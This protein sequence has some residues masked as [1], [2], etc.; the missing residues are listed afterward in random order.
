M[1]DFL[2]NYR[3]IANET[4]GLI[5]LAVLQMLL[6]AVVLKQSHHPDRDWH[7]PGFWILMAVAVGGLLLTALSMAFTIS[8]D[9]ALSRNH[10]GFLLMIFELVFVAGLV[11]AIIGAKAF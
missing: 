9:E 1:R 3:K 4:S 2:N 8:Q 6:I 11:S 7:T 5:A 10:K